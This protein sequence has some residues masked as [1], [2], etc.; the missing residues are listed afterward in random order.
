MRPSRWSPFFALGPQP[1]WSTE[2]CYLRF[3][4]STIDLGDLS[5][6]RHG[7]N[8]VMRRQLPQIG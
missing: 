3:T 6:T 4:L 8:S 2:N 7:I 5:A 1:G